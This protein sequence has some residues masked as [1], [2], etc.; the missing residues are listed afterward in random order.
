MGISG[1]AGALAL[2]FGKHPGVRQKYALLS[3]Y[4]K[5]GIVEFARALVR[6]GYKI[7]ASGGTYK[8]LRKGGIRHMINVKT[9]VGGGAILG[10]KVVTLSRELHAGLL[11][12]LETELAEM[13]RLGIPY[14]DLVCVDTYPMAKAIAEAGATTASVLKQTDIGGPAMLRSGAKGN[15]IVICEFADRQRVI[16]WHKQ[17]KFAEQ[18]FLNDLA[19]KAEGYVA[20]YCLM[21]AKFRSGGVISGQI[22]TQVRTCKYGENAWQ[23][24]AAMFTL[25]TDDPLTLDKF[26]VLIGKPGFTN[27]TDVDGLLQT[28]THI[29][30]AMRLDGRDPYIAVGAKHSNPCG[31]AIGVTPK[32]ALRGMLVG[33]PRAIFGGAIMTTFEINLELARLIVNRPGGNGKSNMDIVVAPAIT[34]EAQALL[35]RPG[36][37]C[38]ML[39][40][41]ALQYLDENSLDKAPRHRHLRGVFLEQPNYTFVLQMGDEEMVKVGRMTRRQECD[42]LLGWAVNATSRSNTITAVKNRKLIGN[43]AGQQDRVGACELAMKRAVDAGHSTQGCVICSDSFIPFEDAVEVLIKAGAKALFATSGS[44]NDAV[45][46]TLCRDNSLTFYRLPDSKARGFYGH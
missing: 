7:I 35:I 18:N 34:E 40:N 31:A 9:L 6:L 1:R 41:P 20:K 29:A 37:R 22:G 12:D 44:Q 28:T 10:H 38:K 3:V 33:D 42:A 21:S 46:E 36:G 2:V 14:I 25:G 43:G 4:N 30:A 45:I 39:V 13:E 11:G 24:P 19:A 32:E 15:R 17:G 5:E 27:W 16:T 26:E 8:E 23:T